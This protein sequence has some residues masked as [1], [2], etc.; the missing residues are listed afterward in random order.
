[1]G[2]PRHGVYFFLDPTEPRTTSGAGPRIVRVGT[3]ALT[4][5][6]RTSLWNRL[7]AHRGTA[8]HGAGNHRGSIFHLLIGECL[9]RRDDNLLPTWGN[10]ST[11]SAAALSHHLERELLLNGERP[12]ETSVSQLIGA[13]SVVCVPVDDRSVRASVERN[14]IALLS[15]FE[16]ALVDPPSP[17][18][19]GQHSTRQRVR[20]SGRWNNDHVEASYEPAFL[21]VLREINGTSLP[22]R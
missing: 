6:S 20:D 21:D 9:L 12:L 15:N 1:M 16:R 2:W 13:L 3:H 17:T 11:A 22:R 18:W 19:L 14:A 10:S 7:S 4:P 5:T 8:S